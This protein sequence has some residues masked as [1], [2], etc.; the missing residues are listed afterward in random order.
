MEVLMEMTNS[1]RQADVFLIKYDT[2]GNKVWS[3]LLGSST[4]MIIGEGMSVDSAGNVYVT[5]FSEGNFDGHTNSNS[6]FQGYVF[7]EV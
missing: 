3:K 2:S 5:G 6:G 4:I 1:R 7:S